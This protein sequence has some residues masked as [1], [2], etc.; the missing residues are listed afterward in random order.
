MPLEPLPTKLDD[1]GTLV[2]DTETIHARGGEV[3]LIVDVEG[4][5]IELLVDPDDV[6]GVSG[7]PRSQE[8]SARQ[9][10]RE[11]LAMKAHY[12]WRPQ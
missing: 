4:R 3:Y 6:A 12:C 1:K 10:A 9:H 2:V 8:A 5:E 11:V 7:T